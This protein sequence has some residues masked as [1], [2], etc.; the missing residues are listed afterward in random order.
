M[1][2]MRRDEM[3]AGEL[4]VHI[5]THMLEQ[6]EHLHDSVVFGIAA[7]DCRYLAVCDSDEAVASGD[8]HAVVDD[9]CENCLGNP[10]QRIAR[11]PCPFQHGLQSA[12]ANRETVAIHA[13][14]QT[15]VLHRIAEDLIAIGKALGN[16]IA[17]RRVVFQRLKS[18]VFGS[19]SHPAAVLGSFTE[20]SQ[21]VTRTAE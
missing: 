3:I 9:L 8:A 7:K 11:N 19:R 15:G 14:E 17:R 20:K 12:G 16:G 13:H 21:E 4:L 1:I 2:E 10:A 6:R 18:Q 5:V